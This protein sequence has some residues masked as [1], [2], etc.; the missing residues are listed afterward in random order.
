MTEHFVFKI[1]GTEYDGMRIPSRLY[2]A[3]VASV[4]KYGE[5][6]ARN[7]N[8]LLSKNTFEP[9]KISVMNNRF[10]DE[11]IHA[12]NIILKNPVLNVYISKNNKQNYVLE[13]EYTATKIALNLLVAT[14]LCDD[15]KS[16]EKSINITLEDANPNHA[17]LTLEKTLRSRYESLVYSPD[18]DSI[19]DYIKIRN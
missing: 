18:A 14:E 4:E 2:S 13:N 12:G 7:F 9:R 8:Y 16:K 15:A 1:E 17:K 11:L 6:T 10:R 3:I 19:F 5:S